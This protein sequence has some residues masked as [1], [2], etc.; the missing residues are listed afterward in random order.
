M[1][2]SGLLYYQARYY[3]PLLGVFV[4]PDTVMPDASSVFDYNRYMVV[5]GNPLNATD[6]SGHCGEPDGGEN[7]VC[8][9]YNTFAKIR[10]RGFRQVV[11]KIHPTLG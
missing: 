9:K 11:A 8:W 1:D 10:K 2:A 6:P 5:R 3:D 4:S 7:T